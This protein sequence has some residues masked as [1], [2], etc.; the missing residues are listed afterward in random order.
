MAEGNNPGEEKAW[1]I[2]AAMNP[3]EVCRAADVS[4]DAASESYRIRSFGI[5][6][7]LSVKKKMISSADPGSGLL[8]RRLGYFF[9]LSVLWYLTNAKDVACTGRPVKLEHLKGGDFFARGSHALPLDAIA[10]KYGK[11]KEGFI[12][13]GVTLDGKIVKTGDAALCFSPLPRIPVTLTLWLEDDEFPARADLLFDSTC[14]LQIPLD[15]IWSVAMMSVL[16][17]M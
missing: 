3:A 4:Y 17:M 2:L 11:D 13:R 10:N 7:S 15:I 14:E 5:E 16:I 6:F 8:L 9:R 1:E 12:Q